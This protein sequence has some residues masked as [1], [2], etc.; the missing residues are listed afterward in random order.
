[1][2]TPKNLKSSFPHSCLSQQICGLEDIHELR[3]PQAVS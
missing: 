3:E 2:K 1:M